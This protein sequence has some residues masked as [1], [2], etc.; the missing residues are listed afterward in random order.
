M[1]L[2]WLSC[3]WLIQLHPRLLL[4]LLLLLLLNKPL[5]HLLLQLLLRRM[6]LLL[7]WLLLLLRHQFCHCC[8]RWCMRLY[9]WHLLNNLCTIRCCKLLL[10]P[11]LLHA[12]L[13]RHTL[14]SL[15]A[16]AAAAAQQAAAADNMPNML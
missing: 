12:F 4:L 14:L 5:E 13:V 16:A 3:L 6:E 1:L 15:C 2:L 10:L 11:L 8:W 7:L 9:C